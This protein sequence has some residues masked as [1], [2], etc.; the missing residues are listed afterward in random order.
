MSDDLPI[1]DFADQLHDDLLV[2]RLTDS[3]NTGFSN[4]LEK[5]ASVDEVAKTASR[6][7]FLQPRWVDYGLS[8]A[9]GPIG[10]LADDVNRTANAVAD[11]YACAQFYYFICIVE[12]EEATIFLHDAWLVLCP[13]ALFPCLCASI[14][15]E[16]LADLQPKSTNVGSC[17]TE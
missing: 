15:R 16:R 4:D 9:V 8:E 7:V 5:G 11:N 17:V 10:F 6:R 1:S 13:P 3:D 14:S 2:K 12:P